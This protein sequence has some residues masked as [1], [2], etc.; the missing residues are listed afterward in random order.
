MNTS[1]YLTEMSNM[2]D[3]AGGEPFDIGCQAENL[4]DIFEE[5][6]NNDSG[7]RVRAVKDWCWWDLVDSE[8]VKVPS[9]IA[10]P[11]LIYS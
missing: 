8:Q 6:K 1:E 5:W 3:N 11:S 7:K 2:L 4:D 10:I 9:D